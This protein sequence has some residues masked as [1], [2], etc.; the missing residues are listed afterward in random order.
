MFYKRTLLS[1][2]VLIPFY[3]SRTTE[4]KM[5]LVGLDSFHFVF[6]LYN[7]FWTLFQYVILTSRAIEAVGVNVSTKP[8]HFMHNVT[9]SFDSTLEQIEVNINQYM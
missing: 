9:M 5:C 4:Q 1:L 8:L 3:P 2:N 7:Y 6:S